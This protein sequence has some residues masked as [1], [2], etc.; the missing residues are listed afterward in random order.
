MLGRCLSL[1][2]WRPLVLGSNL[3]P[4]SDPA[5]N[6]KSLGGPWAA[7]RSPLLAWREEGFPLNPRNL[8]QS[9]NFY[10]SERGEAVLRNSLQRPEHCL[11]T[12]TPPRPA[13]H[14]P[15]SCHVRTGGC[16]EPWATSPSKSFLDTQLAFCMLHA[17]T[18]SPGSQRPRAGS[19]GSSAASESGSP[20]WGIPAERGPVPRSSL[21]RTMAGEGTPA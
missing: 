16:T 20:G 1:Q 5:L 12:S 10:R 17:E 2:S 7:A 21:Q 9:W 13:A 8:F 14:V 19:P 4:S 15:F 3:E 6:P 18:R 11:V